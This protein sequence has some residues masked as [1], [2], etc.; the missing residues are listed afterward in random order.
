LKKLPTMGATVYEFPDAERR[1][2][3]NTLADVA[4]DWAREWDAKGVPASETLKKFMDAVRAK[5]ATPMRN[6]GS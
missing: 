2:W 6:W 4:G 1:K 5:G 3:A